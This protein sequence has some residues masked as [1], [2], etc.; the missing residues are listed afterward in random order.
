MGGKVPPELAKQ[1]RDAK[2]AF[3]QTQKE[4]SKVENKQYKGLTRAPIAE[5]EKAGTKVGRP[6]A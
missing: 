1:L 5:L 6:K 2:G 4:L 3:T